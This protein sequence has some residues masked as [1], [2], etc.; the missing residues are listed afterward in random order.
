[1]GLE[2]KPNRRAVLYLPVL[3]SFG[4][5]ISAAVV[6]CM[7]A[8][9]AGAAGPEFVCSEAA[10]QC[11][12]QRRLRFSAFLFPPCQLKRRWD[13]ETHAP[14][15]PSAW[16]SDQDLERMIARVRKYEQRGFRV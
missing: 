3:T 11:A 8:L 5:R 14:G 6:Q 7:V 10:E 13:P 4:P 15:A 9:R 1:M 2:P 12:T 16:V